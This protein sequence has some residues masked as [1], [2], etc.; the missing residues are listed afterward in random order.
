[1][2]SAQRTRIAG[3]EATGDIVAES[4]HLE[5]RYLDGIVCF[6]ANS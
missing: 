1:M 4:L 5:K 3:A 6:A 2:R